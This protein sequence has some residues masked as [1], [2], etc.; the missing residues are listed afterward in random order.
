[1]AST[2]PMRV[3]TRPNRPAT[4]LVDTTVGYLRSRWLEDWS[5][6]GRCSLARRATYM[7]HARVFGG[8]S[9]SLT[10][11]DPAAYLVRYYRSSRRRPCDRSSKLVLTRVVRRFGLRYAEDRSIEGGDVS[12]S[13][14]GRDPPGPF[15]PAWPSRSQAVIFPDGLA[16]RRQWTWHGACPR[17]VPE[18][19][20]TAD[21]S[22]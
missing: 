22:H 5:Q 21:T 6:P 15:R 12:C 9:R 19:P 11:I 20:L 16:R 2:P 13:L 7:P 4:R 3:P 1:M 18:P 17:D 10:D 8:Q 14:S